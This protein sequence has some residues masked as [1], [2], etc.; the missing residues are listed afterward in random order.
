MVV[1]HGMPVTEAGLTEALTLVTT[2]GPG[3]VQ[4]P[5]GL[6]GAEVMVCPFLLTVSVA[7]GFA[8]ELYWIG[9]LLRV[10]VTVLLVSPGAKVTL[11]GVVVPLAF[12]VNVTGPPE[13]PVLTKIAAA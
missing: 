7:D 1:L 3:N 10:Y 11:P 13:L 2:K 5:E 4:A 9:T 12:H 8:V 6:M